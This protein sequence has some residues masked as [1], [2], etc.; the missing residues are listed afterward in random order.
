MTPAAE[1]RGHTRRT[2]L[3]L[4]ADLLD[5]LDRLALTSR[6]TKTAL[7]ADA[8]RAYLDASETPRG[9]LPFVGIGRSGHGRLSLDA[10]RIAAREL[11]ETAR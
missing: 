6:R 10:G 8:L 1:G 4:P 2:T 7:V 3:L 11:G 5:R 9:Q